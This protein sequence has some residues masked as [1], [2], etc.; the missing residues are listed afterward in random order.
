MR[1][2]GEPAASVCY[3][4]RMDTPESLF[5]KVDEDEERRAIEQARADVA[6]GRV[7]P[8]EEVVRWLQSWGTANELPMPV[9]KPPQS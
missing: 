7:V 4:G 8:H 6:A 2:G 5:D 3:V 9:P 1:A